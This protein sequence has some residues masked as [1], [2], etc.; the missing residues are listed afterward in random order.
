MSPEMV[1][2]AEKNVLSVPKI[3]LMFLHDKPFSLRKNNT[4]MCYSINVKVLSRY[5]KLSELKTSTD[6]IL[7][8]NSV[9]AFYPLE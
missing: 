3:I 9:E 4:L 6:F 7:H 1:I 8:N 2:L 5:F